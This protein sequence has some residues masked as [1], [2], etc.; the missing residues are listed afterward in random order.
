MHDN[1]EQVFVYYKLAKG[2]LFWYDLH[3]DYKLGMATAI[4]NS[5]V[6]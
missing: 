2:E 5:L 1:K 4:A 3:D 6:E